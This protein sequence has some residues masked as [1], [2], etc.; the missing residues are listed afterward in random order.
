MVEV[1]TP[2]LGR[3]PS[4]AAVGTV[5]DSCVAASIPPEWTRREIHG[6]IVSPIHPHS[7][8]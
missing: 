6:T 7:L 4:L 3:A 2:R 8:P 5:S 1:L